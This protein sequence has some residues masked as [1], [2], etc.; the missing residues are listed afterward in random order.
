MEPLD[1]IYHKLW[2]SRAPSNVLCLAWKVLLNRVQSKENLKRRGIIQ[3]THQANC[4]FCLLYE[5][6]TSHLFFTC[7]HSYK[8][9]CYVFRW[10]DIAMVTPEEGRTHLLMFMEP[11]CGRDR[12][13][14]LGVI[15]LAIIWHLWHLSN[16]LIF[17]GEDLDISSAFR[18]DSIQVLA[19]VERKT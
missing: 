14:G 15:W 16:S 10:L 7:C 12:K 9:W 17:N 3:G 11:Y 2:S 8:I 6:S 4:S 5:E 1:K 19:M 18:L 13:T